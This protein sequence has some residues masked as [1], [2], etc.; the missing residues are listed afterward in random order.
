MFPAESLTSMCCY[1]CGPPIYHYRRQSTGFPFGDSS[2]C[3]QCRVGQLPPI[4]L[5]FLPAFMKLGPQSHGCGVLILR[6]RSEPSTDVRF[7]QINK[8]TERG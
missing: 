7:L 5:F 2:L 8:K 4:Y 6:G 1:Y 3:I